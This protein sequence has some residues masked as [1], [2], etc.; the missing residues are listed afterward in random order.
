[1]KLLCLYDKDVNMYLFTG[2]GGGLDKFS[3]LDK[4]GVFE[5]LKP[6]QSAPHVSCSS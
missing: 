2:D 3:T 6:E 5:S 4:G 1:M